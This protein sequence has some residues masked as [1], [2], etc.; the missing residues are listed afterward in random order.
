MFYN[1]ADT[2]GKILKYITENQ[3]ISIRLVAKE[4]I[5]DWTTVN[6]HVNKLIELQIVE[7]R[8]KIDFGL[9]IRGS[10]DHTT[11]FIKNHGYD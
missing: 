4:F 11:L 3:G 10:V 2:R 9:G 6:Y 1:R 5:L 8:R 7:K